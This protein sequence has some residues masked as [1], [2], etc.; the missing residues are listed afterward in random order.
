[1][2]SR[3]DYNEPF[4]TINERDALISGLTAEKMQA[5]AKKFLDETNRAKFVLLPEGGVIKQ[6]NVISRFNWLSKE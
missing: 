5:A 1:M 2:Q 4:S 6:L 3:I